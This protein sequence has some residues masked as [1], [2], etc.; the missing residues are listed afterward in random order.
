M[1]EK[2]LL[3]AATVCS[4]NADGLCPDDRHRKQP[5]KSNADFLNSIQLDTSA[6]HFD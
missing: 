2:L 6:K 3:I 1:L 5:R 4:H